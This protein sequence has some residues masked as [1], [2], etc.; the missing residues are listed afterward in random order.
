MLETEITLPTVTEA[1]KNS[2]KCI[3]D[4]KVRALEEIDWAFSTRVL[5]NG[6]DSLHPYP[7]KFITQIP[8]TIL[9]VLAPVP[10]TV[11]LDPFCGSGTTLL[12]A[13]QRG[14]ESIGIDLNP[15]ACLI[16]RVKTSPTPSRL[17]EDAE[18]IIAEACVKKN[19]TIPD[20][21]NLDHW[22]K[23]DIKIAVGALVEAIGKCSGTPTFDALRLALSSILVRVSNQESDTRYAAINKS[24]AREDVFAAFRTSCSKLLKTLDSRDWKLSKSTVI[25]GD[26]LSLP[27]S[28]IGR[29]VGVVI[30]SPPYPNA[31]EYWLYHK[32]RMWWLGFDPLAVKASEIGARAHFFKRDRHTA[33]HFKEQMFRTLS[34]IDATLLPGGWVCFVVGRSKI[35]GAIVDNAETIKEVGC[36]MGFSF[37]TRIERVIAANRKSFNLT[38][39]NIKTESIVVLR[40]P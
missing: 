12:A 9:D 16:S 8:G 28:E 40:K 3:G 2:H 7:A 31:Y 39:A 1:R 37:E 36:E 21:P 24:V 26:I 35:H 30:T 14:F 5:G 10:G 27:V 32:Y 22:F 17:A 15:I 18:A 11:V 6:I 34:L 33:E 4:P 25:E 13:Q 20:I 23:P 38:H 29:R 19:P